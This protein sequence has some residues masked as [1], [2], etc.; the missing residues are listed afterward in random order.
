MNNQKLLYDKPEWI[1]PECGSD[2]TIPWGFC[3]GGD[4]EG[5]SEITYGRICNNCPLGHEYRITEVRHF[6][7][8][9]ERRLH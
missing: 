8:L 5:Y 3:A 9:V 2:N 6:Y 1:C 7:E 4:G